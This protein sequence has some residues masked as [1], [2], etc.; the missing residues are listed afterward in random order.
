[1][2]FEIIHIDETDSTNRWLREMKQG[3]GGGERLR[4]EPVGE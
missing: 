2:K 1:M 4:N 3:D